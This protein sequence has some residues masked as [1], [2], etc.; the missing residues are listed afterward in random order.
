A[1]TTWHELQE[2]IPE[3]D[4]RFSKNSICPRST[5]SSVM[6]LSAGAS[7]SA[8]IGSKICAYLLFSVLSSCWVSCCGWVPQLASRKA[9]EKVSP[10]I[11]KEKIDDGI[12]LI[13]VS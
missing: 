10:S 2:I 6:G 11:G 3:R 5:F 8:G 1:P 12:D 4:R 7:A 9:E 13:M